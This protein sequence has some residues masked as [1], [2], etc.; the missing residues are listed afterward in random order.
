[1]SISFFEETPT[2]NDIDFNNNFY[3]SFNFLNIENMP[4]LIFN[5]QKGSGKTIKI[6]SLLCSLL[7]KRVYTIK[8]NEIELDKRIFKFKSSIYHLEID[9]IELQ[10][11]ERTFFNNYLKEYIDSRNIG[12]DIPKI[13]YLINI[14][15]INKNSLLY[16]RKLIESTYQSCKYI[17]ETNNIS[18]IPESLI[19]RFL[20][21]RVKSPQRDEIELVIKNIIKNNK[22]KITK[23]II[24]NIIDY[25]AKYKTYYD[26][27]NIFLA[28]NYYIDTKEILKNNFYSI[29]D[30][31]INI[32]LLKKLNFTITKNIKTICEKIFINCYDVNELINIIS[33]I[34]LDKYKNNIDICFKIIELSTACDHDLCRSTGKYFIHLENYFIKL[35]LLL[36]N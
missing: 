16:L 34:L 33:K 35:I 11:N 22:L 4:N 26:L 24:N 31:L 30:E 9:C 5:G 15:K 12:L 17:F 27:N 3:K 32:I 25:D 1:M 10:N 19:S 14:D 6:Y 23:K 18:F 28:L 2:I 8:N 7:D 20:I 21:I 29:I 36:N 13:I